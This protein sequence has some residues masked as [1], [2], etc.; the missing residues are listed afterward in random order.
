MAPSAVSASPGECEDRLFEAWGQYFGA[1]LLVFLGGWFLV[2]FGDAIADET[3]LGRVWA[4]VILLAT[5]TSLP[6]LVTGITA[7]RQIDS[8]NLAAGGAFGANGLNLLVIAVLGLR[9]REMLHDPTTETKKMGIAGILVTLIAAGILVLGRDAFGVPS[10][11]IRILPGLLIVSYVVTALWTIGQLGSVLPSRSTLS[12]GMPSLS[13]PKPSERLVKS[14]GGYLAAVG[15][16]TASGIWLAFAADDVTDAMG[17]SSSFVGAQFLPLSTT[18]PEFSVAVAS[19]RLGAPEMALSNLLGSNMFN[20]GIVLAVDS[21]AY[22]KGA[23]F[24]QISTVHEVAAMAGL[25]M[26]LI[27]IP[28]LV[29]ASRP[30][31]ATAATKSITMIAVYATMSTLIFIL[32]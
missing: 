24:T 26:T 1:S 4:G 3:G 9:W 23:F 15:I 10:V 16:V 30:W 13:I 32:S 31:G 6:E 28:G 29:F 18:L 7:V 21:F 27:F 17:W 19:L 25:A 20:I 11:V 14:A 22:T 2:R 5:A 8:P 12:G